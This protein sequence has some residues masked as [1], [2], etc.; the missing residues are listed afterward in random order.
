MF[1]TLITP[2]TLA[3]YLAE[4]NWLI[5]DCRF[6]LSDPNAGEHAYAQARIPGAR[7][8]HLERDLS[9]PPTAHSGRHPLPAPADFVRTLT[10]W[11]VNDQTQV[12]V[13]DDSFGAMAVRLWWMLRWVEHQNVAL[14]NGGLPRWKRLNLPMDTHPVTPHPVAHPGLGTA[15]RVPNHPD[16]LADTAM[17]ENVHRD[18]E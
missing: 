3:K 12:V 6:T 7:Y 9:V 14:L 10:D 11:G 16:M 5:I 4:P 2:E 8:A 17:V 18:P 1:T 15:I 13:Y